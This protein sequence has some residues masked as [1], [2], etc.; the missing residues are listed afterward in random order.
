MAAG[1]FAISLLPLA[2]VT[3]ISFSKI[4]FI[5]PLAVIIF[6]EKPGKYLIYLNSCRGCDL[7]S[8]RGNIIDSLYYGL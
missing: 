8:V 3:S 4:L 1:F 2:N 5:I 6:K 7:E